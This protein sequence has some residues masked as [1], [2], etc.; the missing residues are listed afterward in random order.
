MP[1]DHELTACARK[2]LRN[3]PHTLAVITHNAK[4]MVQANTGLYTTASAARQLQIETDLTNRLTNMLVERLNSVFDDLSEHQ[5]D[6]PC[7]EGADEATA[8]AIE[9]A[10]GAALE[11][12][13][14]ALGIARHAIEQV[15]WTP[16]LAPFIENECEVLRAMCRCNTS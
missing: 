15:D 4:L 5:L 1:K 7:T 11:Y 13:A 2:A 3:S 6:A 14:I 9:H 8:A 12:R 16:I 10:H